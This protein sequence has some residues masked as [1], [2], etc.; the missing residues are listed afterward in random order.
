MAQRRKRQGTRVATCEDMAQQRTIDRDLARSDGE[1]VA[2]P[3][4]DGGHTG[5]FTVDADM[6]QVAKAERRNYPTPETN[7][8]PT[9]TGTMD[10]ID[11][12]RSVS[13]VTGTLAVLA[14]VAI[15]IVIV[16]LVAG[17]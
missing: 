8:D 12:R 2:S 6:M 13:V 7:E 5:N 3:P 9:L 1:L 16:L 17:A 10:R 15:S 4:D 14:V 11:P